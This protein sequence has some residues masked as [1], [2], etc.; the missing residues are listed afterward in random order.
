V[1]GRKEPAIVAELGRPETPEEAASRRTENSRAHRANQTFVNLI[2]AILACLAV[3]L[4]IVIVVVRPTQPP[5]AAVDF[6][7]VASQA[8]SETDV[9]LTVPHLPATWSSNDAHVN[10]VSGITTWY[11]GFITP[12]Q[13]FIALNQGIAANPTWQ[14]NLLNGSAQS[15]TATIDGVRWAVFDERS[16]N[17]P[18]N[19]AYALATT[20]G[21][22]TF[23]LYGTAKDSEF[24]ALASAIASDVLA[25][26]NGTP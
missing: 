7:S 13:Q 23:V 1:T 19:L 5:R 12:N 11:I 16:H 18:G 8:Q 10:K 6:A 4:L 20:A 22:T 24:E 2:G 3:V 15:G 9:A 17:A 26:K 21:T 14:S 25:L